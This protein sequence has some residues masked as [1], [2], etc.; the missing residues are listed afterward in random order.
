MTDDWCGRAQ[1]RVGNASLWQLVITGIKKQAKH[2]VGNKPV[3]TLSPSLLPEF[4]PWLPL[5]A[6]LVSFMSA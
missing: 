4:L 1:L 2:A 5:I 6:V 3:S